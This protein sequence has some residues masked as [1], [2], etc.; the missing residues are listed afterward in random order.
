MG[1]G[2]GGVGN[3]VRGAEVSEGCHR[4]LRWRRHLRMDRTSRRPENRVPVRA[5]TSAACVLLLLLV[6]AR[7]CRGT[8]AAVGVVAA[9]RTVLAPAVLPLGRFLVVGGVVLALLLV[10]A[11][12]VLTMRSWRS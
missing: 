8:S 10:D 11:V 9:I 1:V 5:Q 3:R 7:V 12:V 2:G 6:A 4:G